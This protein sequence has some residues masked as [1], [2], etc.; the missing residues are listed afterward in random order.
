MT[1]MQATEFKSHSVLHICHWL[2]SLTNMHNRVSRDRSKQCLLGIWS[3]TNMQATGFK[4]NTVTMHI[5]HWLW[6]MTNMHSLSLNHTQ[7]PCTFVIDYGQ[8][9][10]CRL[11]SLN[12]THFVNTEFKLFLAE[13]KLFLAVF[14]IFFAVFD[15]HMVHICHWSCHWPCLYYPSTT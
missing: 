8:W 4:S 15:L 3:M 7:C 2:W 12:H 13:S 14:K 11:L 1:N 9:H 5:C 10:I 6:S